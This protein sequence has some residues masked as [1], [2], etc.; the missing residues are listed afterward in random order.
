MNLRP[1]LSLTFALC[2]ASN[3]AA[4]GSPPCG[5]TP[6][7]PTY[8]VE[9]AANVWSSIAGLPG[10]VTLTFTSADDGGSTVVFP[11]TF[12][13]AFYGVP[14]TQ[15]VVCTNGF[16]NFGAAS[17]TYVN[18]HP[19]DP[20]LPNDAACPWFDDLHLGTG[21]PT[22]GRGY[23]RFDATAGFETWTV[24][25]NN[26]RNYPST[27]TATFSFQAVFHASTHVLKPNV[28]EYHYDRSSGPSVPACFNTLLATPSATVGT[29]APTT[30]TTVAGLGGVDATE[31]GAANAT[32]PD[33]DLRLIPLRATTTIHSGSLSVRRQ[34]PF[35]TIRG[36]LGTVQVPNSC[37]TTQ[38]CTDNDNSA[39][40]MGRC[41]PIP[42]KFDLEGRPLACAN[43][44]SNGVL[45]LGPGNFGTPTLNAALPG[46]AQTNLALA[47]FWDD[48]EG[49]GPGS[50]MFFRV[51]G[52]A[53]C[54]VMTFEWAD[55]DLKTGTTGDCVGTG[56]RISFQV[57]LFEG[58]AGSIIASS[59]FCPYDFVLPGIG[60]D[61]VEYHYDHANFVAPGT[62]FSATIGYDNRSGAIGAQLPGSP[63]IAT[64]PIDA[65]GAPG[66]VILDVCDTGMLRY[67]GNR[68]TSVAIG[69]LPEIK[70]NGIAPNIGNPFGLEIV[71]ATAGSTG[72]FL[73]DLGGPIPGM[74]TPVPCGGIGLSFGTLWVN[75]TVSATCPIGGTPGRCD[76]CCDLPLAIPN[77]TSL[78]GARVFVQGA[79]VY[80]LPSF[81]LG[82]DMTEGMAI[83]IGG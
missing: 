66:K 63:T 12:V 4:Q 80:V 70:G 67:Y 60:G 20:A 29:D 37:I 42:W 40:T 49:S 36:L 82:I 9:Q 58:S 18:H 33:C 39:A 78:I 41:I 19:D 79:A 24:E 23:S 55:M 69:C 30:A 22:P 59:G 10:T 57:K 11:A 81:A 83:T 47:P 38:T 1:I 74:A 16:V 21:T 2:A 62:P 61:R 53:G 64:L 56:G 44:N 50:G 13:F 28:I 51:D 76:G 54:R 15:G 77:S 7:V 68:T 27:T 5:T 35:C 25:W 8:R 65:T 32:F 26:V 73:I 52:Q 14:K 3:P 71:G 45:T 34:E 31:R 43:M 75:P 72:V 17:T 6:I 46:L 48:L